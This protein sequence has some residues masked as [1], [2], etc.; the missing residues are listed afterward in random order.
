MTDGSDTWKAVDMY[1]NEMVVK[2][3][4]GIFKTIIAD[5]LSCRV[6]L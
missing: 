1:A 2:T 6:Y 5:L 4:K 3:S